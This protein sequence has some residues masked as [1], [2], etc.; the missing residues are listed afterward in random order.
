MECLVSVI[1]PVYNTEKYLHRCIDSILNQNL[2][3]MEVILV[4]DGSTDSSGEICDEY[5]KVDSRVKVIHQSNA[6]SSE[7]RNAG[8]SIAVGKYIAFVDSDDYLPNKADIYSSAVSALEQNDDDIMAWLWQFQDDNGRMVIDSKNVP[9]FF[10]GKMTTHEFAKGLYYGSYAN[11][12]VVCVC[13][14]LYKKDFIENQMFSGRI[15]EDDDWMTRI[16]INNGNVFCQNDFWYV[17]VQNNSSLSHSKFSESN[18][19]FL[20]VIKNRSRLFEDDDFIRN[21]SI[22]L[23]LDLYIEY[24]YKA[25]E[26][27][28]EPYNDLSTYK[29]YL[30]QLSKT[31]YISFKDKIRYTLFKMSPKLYEFLVT[32][33][34]KRS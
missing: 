6:G 32:K 7:A 2:T 19:H 13:N 18:Y 4:D 15:N 1:V 24:W 34:R 17:Y 3:D 5:E 23:Y 20:D 16:L 25:K 28:I 10:Q 8:L 21:H 14:K 9:E 31:G 29:G 33:L 30:S 11:G 27:G 26:S 12:L 22:K